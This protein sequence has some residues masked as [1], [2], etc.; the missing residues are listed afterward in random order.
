MSVRRARGQAALL[1]GLGEPV[2]EG[3]GRFVGVPLE[4]TG[5]PGAIVEHAE[6]MRGEP[7]AG[8][9]EH[10]ARALVEI[11]MPEAVDVLGLE[12]A[13]LEV[14]AAARRARA[15]PGVAAGAAPRAAA[16]GRA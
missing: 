5:E 3:L 8:G 15:A 9:G 6:Q 1:D 4:V 13:H 11:Q 10:L 16:R 7:R 12:A 2:H 14:L